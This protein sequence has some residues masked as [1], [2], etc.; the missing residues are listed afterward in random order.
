MRLYNFRRGTTCSLSCAWCKVLRLVIE[1]ELGDAQQRVW[2]VTHHRPPITLYLP[3]VNLVLLCIESGEIILMVLIGV[4]PST[5]VIFDRIACL[6]T[7]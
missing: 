5:A 2:Y 3:S 1:V 4:G 7:A 6:F